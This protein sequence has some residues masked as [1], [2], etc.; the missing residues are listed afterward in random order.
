MNERSIDQYEIL[1]E[2]GRGG[3]SV[4]YLVTDRADGRNYAMKVLR[5]DDDNS[6]EKLEQKADHLRADAIA[7]RAEAEVLQEEAVVLKELCADEQGNAVSHPGIPVF[8]ECVCDRNG[9][10]TGFVMEY[11]EGRSLQKILEEGRSF[12]VRE[13][14][15][16]GLQLCGIIEL[17]HGQKPPLIFRDLKPANILVRLGGEFVLVD[18]GA[19]RK[20]RKSAGTDTMQLGTDGYA[21]PEQYGGWE[22][23]DERTDIYG[24]GAVLHHMVTG[25]PPLETGLRPLGEVMGTEG[26]S[27][28][29]SE[30]AKV[31]MRCC[32][33]AP[34]MRY[35]SC[36][37]LEKALQGVLR[38]R[39]RSWSKGS[40]EKVWNRFLLL[41]NTAAVC[42][43]LA[44]VLAASAAGAKTVEYCALIEKAQKETSIEEKKAVYRRA[45]ALRPEDQEA[46]ICFLREL[47]TDCVITEEEKSVLDDVLFGR[48]N[49]GRLWEKAAGNEEGNLDR[50]RKKRPG[51]YAALQMELGK[52]Y[53]ACYEGGRE[54]AKQCFRNA[55]A[56]GGI[57]FGD[58]GYGNCTGREMDQGTDRRMERIGGGSGAGSGDK[59]ERGLRGSSM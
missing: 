26:E 56:E 14:A 27:W 21:A 52:A 17:L 50:M 46:Y 54:A 47:V 44:F 28:Q 32:M 59:R 34:L 20:L 13:A 33:T 58:R 2:L 35:S 16:A 57:W 7:R 10:F 3:T 23:S 24:I 43:V 38:I 49:A 30:M 37:E 51:D 1:R 8:K 36:K 22:Q 25:R 31:L 15:E 40:R 29:Y 6:P 53:F 45:V 9:G 19:V 18:Y 55:L 5:K 12:T 41:A 48:A 39:E 42:L 11:V 4:V